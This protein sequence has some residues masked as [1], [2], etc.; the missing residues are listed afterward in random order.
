M[1]LDTVTLGPPGTN[2]LSIDGDK[3]KK[4]GSFSL[5]VGSLVDYFGLILKKEC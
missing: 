5:L 1:F 2:Q 4:S 3:A